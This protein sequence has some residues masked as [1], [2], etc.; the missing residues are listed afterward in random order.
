[1]TP[2]ALRWLASPALPPLVTCPACQR[3]F[4]DENETGYSSNNVLPCPYCGVLT[5]YPNFP[6]EPAEELIAMIEYFYQEGEKR[7]GAMMASLAARISTATAKHHSIDEVFRVAE[8]M[9]DL[10]DSYDDDELRDILVERLQVSSDESAYLSLEILKD[11]DPFFYEHKVVVVLT[12]TLLEALFSRLLV[13]IAVRSG[14][15]EDSERLRLEKRFKGFDGRATRFEQ[16]VRAPF[17]LAFKTAEPSDF[18]DTWK[19]MRGIR[20][21]FMHGKTWTITESSAH[22]AR[23]LA[24]ASPQPFA[25]L[26]NAYALVMPTTLPA[27]A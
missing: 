5:N 22:M 18:Y 19:V 27:D 23:S 16:L 26:Q 8:E 2:E 14:K 10:Q 11:Y 1:M 6:G 15:D 13:A 4:T 9:R 20:N 24:L 25:A 3:V 7:V 12:C 17:E 21:D